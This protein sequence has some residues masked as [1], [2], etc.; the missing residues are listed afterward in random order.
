MPNRQKGFTLIELMIVVAIIG[1]LSAVAIPAYQDYI[2]RSTLMTAYQEINSGRVAYEL[3]VNQGYGSQ[4]TTAQLSLPARTEYCSLS[5]DSPDTQTRVANKAITC[6]LNN[7][8]LFGANAEIYLT[9]SADGKYS[10]HTNN[11][12]L[13][14]KPKE[15][16]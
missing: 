8:N 5:V 3:G 9:R 16:S 6:T 15:C 2:G 14:F 7:V 11:I 10:C 4:I 1:I 12:P 13:K